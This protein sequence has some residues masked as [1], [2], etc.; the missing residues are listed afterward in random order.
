[1]AEKVFDVGVLAMLCDVDRETVRRWRNRGVR[2]VTLESTTSEAIKG[3][4]MTFTYSAILEFAKVYPKIMTPALQ[5][6][7]GD[8]VIT[9]AVP[10]QTASI[11]PTAVIS[12]TTSGSS[13]LKQLLL[14]RK[15]LLLQELEHINAEIDR[16]TD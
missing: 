3:K 11:A 16:L 12:S 15:Q 2:G 14:E 1:M 4:P 9:A 7:M 13:Y 10:T 6:A 8:E 5:R